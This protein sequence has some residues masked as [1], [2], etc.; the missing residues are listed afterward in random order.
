MDEVA[1]LLLTLIGR[2]LQIKRIN[3]TKQIEEEI[4]MYWHV[5]CWICSDAVSA[6]ME[7]KQQFSAYPISNHKLVVEL[8]IVSLLIVDDQ[9]LIN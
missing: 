4:I 6:R 9:N 8:H 1:S 5:K 2:H 7:I 3:I